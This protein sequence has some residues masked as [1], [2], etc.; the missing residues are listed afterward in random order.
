[1]L[2]RKWVLLAGISFLL[3]TAAPVLAASGDVNNDGRIDSQDVQMIDDYLNGDTT[4]QDDQIR[5]ADADN[6]GRITARDKDLLQR[7]LGNLAVKSSPR[8]NARN[9][10]VD[11]NS[12]SSGVVVDKATGKPLSGV[13]VS[14]P[15]EGITVRTDAQG[16]FQLPRSTAGKILTAKAS[17]YA[18]AAVTNQQGKNFELQ[19]EKL[20]PRLQVIDDELHHLG[21]GNY[22]ASSA[23]ASDF[24][25]RNQ[26]YRY[27][28]VFALTKLPQG[29]MSLRIGSLIGLDTNQAMQSGQSG[30]NL[31]QPDGLKIFL[32]GQLINQIYL[33]SDN[34]LVPLPRWLL[35][36]GNN[37]LSIETPRRIT[38]SGI[39]FSDNGG[40]I[41]GL[42]QS[43]G[44]GRNL[45]MNAGMDTVDYDDIEF[46]HLVLEDPNGQARGTFN[47]RGRV[48]QPNP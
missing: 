32:N 33:N 44:I 20:S 17:Q 42:L 11:L 27:E 3:V 13:E 21:D 26:G 31:S 30:L 1:M 45:G 34:I 19:L 23:N 10:Q 37:Q 12:A 41:I 9:S 18:P 4:L 47:S 48:Y 24:R 36:A 39:S 6:D 28:R 38:N 25:L 7:R 15:D 40:G 35:R 43:F 8:S 46:A 22:S 2:S 16:R 14:L 5:A 29:D